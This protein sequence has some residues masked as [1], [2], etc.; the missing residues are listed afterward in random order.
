[1][2]TKI[3]LR[4]QQI[5]Q[6][7]L[8]ELSWGQGQRVAATIQFPPELKQ[9]YTTW[10]NH[11]LNFYRTIHVPL[12]KTG[13]MIDR[14]SA[15]GQ[16]GQSTTS[17]PVPIAPSI[18]PIVE[19]TSF[20]GK[21]G[22]SGNV[23]APPTNWQS[24]L[25]KSERQLVDGFHRWLRQEELYDI[26]MA[27][28]QVAKSSNVSNSVNAAPVNLFI[29]CD[30]LDLA[31]LPWET[32]SLDLE[33]A[34]R[35]IRVI[36]TASTIRRS[37]VAHKPR[38]RARIL[39][40]VGHD[41]KLDLQT[42]EQL[43]RSHFRKDDFRVIGWREGSSL[44]VLETEIKQALTDSRGW[45]VL[46]F[47]GHSN[48][49]PLAGGE[50]IIAPKASIQISQI[51]PQ[52]AIAIERGLQFALFNSCKGLDIAEAL[53]DLGFSQVA[54]MRE[55]IHNRVAQEFLV[56]FLQALESRHNVHQA[57]V[58]AS[59]YLK[60]EKDITY[61]SA[62]LVPSFF[63]H[64]E[65]QPFVLPMPPRLK[66]KLHEVATVA[67]LIALSWPLGVQDWLLGQ[68]LLLQAQYRNLTRQDA[69]EA[70]PV[71]MVQ[72]D[73]ESIRRAQI[74]NP[75]PMDRTYLAQLV[76]QLS[77]SNAAVIGID[78]LLDRPQPMDD[79]EL[80]AAL[81]EAAITA[82]TRFVF[83]SIRED[84]HSSQ[85]LQAIAPFRNIVGS[86]SG[87]VRFYGGA[88][89][90]TYHAPVSM[91]EEE[92]QKTEAIQPFSYQVAQL[93]RQQINPE[94]QPAEPI[95]LGFVTQLSYSFQQM[96]L[97]PIVDFSLP[98]GRVFRKVSAWQLLNVANLPDVL[99][100]APT[101]AV[102]IVPGGYAQAGVEGEGEDNLKL[103]AALRY[104]R[105]QQDPPD[106]RETL[107]A[108]ELH[109][110]MFHH[111]WKGR[112]VTPI[113]DAWMILAV[114]IAT[115]YALSMLEWR[116][117]SR[118]QGCFILLGGNLL[119]TLVSFQLFVSSAAIALPILLPMVTMWLYAT[120]WLLSQKR[121]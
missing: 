63:C 59:N 102:M 95:R 117:T 113:P 64:P 111:F 71:L 86:L 40:V 27:I 104:W 108:G 14:Q 97:H 34:T 60:V 32:W 31:R 110:Y 68:R 116:M 91:P 6:S 9:L 57:L 19:Q 3:Y 65:A 94:I 48:E 12:K 11:Y 89:S 114:A 10:Q 45:D 26:R 66:P 39:I 72:V 84:S 121:S 74:D 38:R 103:P 109:A 119:Y 22:G 106:L 61:P 16:S 87:D 53:I 76:R 21:G 62:Y 70:P 56:Q 43:L 96:W 58:Q 46:F 73:P 24:E 79:A 81:Q 18:S 99:N 100:Y 1:M 17:G 85:W 52:L 37:R 30:P 47:A 8:F 42:D 78:Y 69:T 49:A 105:N 120:P 50:L 90:Q 35:K 107:P 92:D 5:E 80:A 36:R 83:A 98:P 4:V 112:F 33:F 55:P 51:A 25:G 101:W 44:E 54:I 2:E 29:T 118:R 13:T 15:V 88:N 20:R 93:Y 82:K 23:S 41:E 28:A 67:A 75:W 77:A 115:K 7:C